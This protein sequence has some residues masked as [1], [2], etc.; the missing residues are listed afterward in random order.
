MI[1]ETYGKTPEGYTYMV[2]VKYDTGHRNGYVGVSQESPL[3][4]RPYGSEL[5][6]LGYSIEMKINVHGGV[7]YSG[8]L[9]RYVVGGENPWYFGFD[10]NHLDDKII[11][12]NDMYEILIKSGQFSSGEIDRT[13]QRYTQVYS[14]MVGISEGTTKSKDY[15]VAEC[16]EMSKQ[17]KIIEDK[18]N[19]ND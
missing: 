1:I 9:G 4:K 2:V 17:L 7:T 15:V 6:G 18:L 12:P 8:M 5:D 3:Y 19:G 14:M 16:F 13:M 10:C 11:E